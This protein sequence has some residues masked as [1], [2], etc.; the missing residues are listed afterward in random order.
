MR[1]R[2]A[3]IFLTG[4]CQFLCTGISAV[5]GAEGGPIKKVIETLKLLLYRIVLDRLD[6]LFKE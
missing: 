6:A 1:N 5:R 4:N 3:K 2:G